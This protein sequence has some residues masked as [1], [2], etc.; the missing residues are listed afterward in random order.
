MISYQEAIRQATYLEMR[1]DKNVFVCGIGITS[2][3]KAFGTTEGIEE[4]FG[5]Q[6]CFDTPI[7]EDA[8]TGFVFG[9]AV[10]GLKPIHVHI[11]SDFFIL[12]MNQLANIISPFQYYVHGTIPLPIVFRVIIGRGFGQGAQHSKSLLSFFTHIPGF[13]VIAP[14]SP[15][16]AKGLLTS[17]IK[18]K[19]P[20]IFFEHRWLYWSEQKVKEESFEI[21][22][23]KGKIV[24]KGED[25]TI[26]AISWMNVE[27]ILAAEILKK[28]NISI[29][30]IDPRTLY[31]LDKKMIVNSVRKTKKCLVVDCDWTFGGMS[32]EIASIVSKECFKVLQKPVERLGFKH[33]PCPTARHLENSFYPNAENIVRKAEKLLDLSAMN[34]DG[35]EFFSNEKKF[36]GP[37]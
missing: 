25:L 24:K 10:R 32:G 9:A 20:V 30:I 14:S 29:E 7:S 6:R 5:S 17:A 31:P 27:A 33:I 1:K 13:K 19:N 36:K 23:G 28:R 16:D 21:E 34:L 15:Q 4:K 37:L 3:S 22:I 8:M 12:G 35:I 2:H 18:D 26:I 11:R